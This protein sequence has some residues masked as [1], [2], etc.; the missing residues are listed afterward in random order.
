MLMPKILLCLI[1]FLFFLV[2]LISVGGRFG[3]YPASC[4]P[5]DSAY[6]YAWD[7]IRGYGKDRESY[8]IMCERRIWLS[9][10]CIIGSVISLILFFR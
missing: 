4:N 3:A 10:V 2:L 7:V 1:V 8:R 6:Y 5:N 9:L